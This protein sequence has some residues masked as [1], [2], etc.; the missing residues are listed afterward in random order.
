MSNFFV[1]LIKSYQIFLKPFFIAFGLKS[2]CVFYPNC[3]EY[4]KKA[5]LKFNLF[6]AFWLTAKRI[7]RCHPWQKN[8]L[9]PI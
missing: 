4:A 9:D 6:K 2:E 8:H 5:F 3:S 1:F 7:L